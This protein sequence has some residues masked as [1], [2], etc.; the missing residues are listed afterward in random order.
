MNNK[1]EIWHCWLLRLL[2]VSWRGKQ[3]VTGFSYL[4]GVSSSRKMSSGRWQG[5][6]FLFQNK[7]RKGSPTWPAK[8]CLNIIFTDRKVIFCCFFY[9]EAN[10][11]K[12]IE[13]LLYWFSQSSIL[14]IYSGMQLL[15]CINIYMRYLPRDRNQSNTDLIGCQGTV[16]QP[17]WQ[18]RFFQG[19]LEY[20]LSNICIYLFLQKK[21]SHLLCAKLCMNLWQNIT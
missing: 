16:V 9:I 2:V 1:I 11:N 17:H 18:L 19:G 12:P 5:G 14:L 8:S 4:T 6:S 20:I 15:F 21:K 10:P 13:L 7:K 3:Y